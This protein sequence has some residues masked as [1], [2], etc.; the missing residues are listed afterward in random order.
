MFEVRAINDREGLRARHDLVRE[1]LREK[2]AEFGRAA[3]KVGEVRH[4][5]ALAVRRFDLRDELLRE[6]G[7]LG[8]KSRG[9]P[10][11]EGEENKQH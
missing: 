4:D 2:A 6:R 5:R 10:G 3:L 7:Q 9:R 11:A 8:F 1:L